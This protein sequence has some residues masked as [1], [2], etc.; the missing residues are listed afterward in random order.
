MHRHVLKRFEKKSQIQKLLGGDPC[1]QGHT[2]T[3]TTHHT[4]KKT[5]GSPPKRQE[6]DELFLLAYQPNKILP[7]TFGSSVPTFPSSTSRA[8]SPLPAHTRLSG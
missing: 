8:S 2:C 1:V 5:I 3:H 7:P 4:H 6:H